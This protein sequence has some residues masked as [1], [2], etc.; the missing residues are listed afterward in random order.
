[1]SCAPPPPKKNYKKP[2]HGLAS[3]CYTGRRCAWPPKRALPAAARPCAAVTH[4]P[5]AAPSGT[6]RGSR[7]R[8]DR[9]GRRASRS[10]RTAWLL[11]QRRAPSYDA[12][13]CM[14]DGGMRCF[15][16]ALQAE[17]ERLDSERR[18]QP[19]RAEPPPHAPRGTAPPR[20]F[21]SPSGGGGRRRGGGRR[22]EGEWP[23]RCGGRGRSRRRGWSWRTR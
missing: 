14:R 5:A 1:M 15:P 19:G 9:A 11:P 6:E 2:H 13:G 10:A 12:A 16:P 4:D 8:A 22:A 3:R 17:F 21:D 18:K 7:R 20:A 23:P